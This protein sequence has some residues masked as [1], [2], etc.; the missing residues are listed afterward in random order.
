MLSPNALTMSLVATSAL[1]PYGQCDITNRSSLFG[2]ESRQISWDAQ[3][4]SAQST[5]ESPSSSD[6]VSQIS[7]F[8]SNF[9]PAL[10]IDI[11][12]VA[13]GERYRLSAVE[14]SV[15]LSSSAWV[16]STAG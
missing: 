5:C 14:A 7:A 13:T 4:S 11:P 12:V 2:I 8:G 1:A 16:T 10:S 15:S 6:W 9:A 3:P